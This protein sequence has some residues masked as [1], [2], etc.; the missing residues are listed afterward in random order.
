MIKIKDFSFKYDDSET[1]ALEGINMEIKKGAFLGIIGSSG[2]GKTTLTYA[3]NGIIPHFYKGDFY[4]EILVNSQDTVDTQPAELARIIG[5]VFQDI[6]GQMVASIVEDEI[7]FGLENFGIPR[8]EIPVRIDES[9]AA[10]GISDLRFRTIASLSGGQKQKVAIAAI[11]ALKPQ[12]LLL[13]EPTGE[14]D[15][16]SS[17]QIFE[18]LRILN[19]EHGITIIIV[20]QKIMLLCEF[21]KEILLLVD[22]KLQTH[23]TTTEILQQGDK[24]KELGINTPRIAS[25]ANKLK[26]KNLYTGE[27]PTTIEEAKKMVGEIVL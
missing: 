21:A 7:L 14:L 6:D 4:G 20:E 27:V 2:A 18:M 13:D 26:A 23:G 9:L 11:I 17:R 16:V 25:L 24:L 8:E 3:I 12:I 22:N 15:P 10:T 1:Y 19:E 5:S